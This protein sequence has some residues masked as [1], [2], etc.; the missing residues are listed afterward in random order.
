MKKV[1]DDG[2]F[3]S[4]VYLQKIGVIADE[5]FI[6]RYKTEEFSFRSRNKE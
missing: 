2:S 3:A 6:E 1:L 5:I 4:K